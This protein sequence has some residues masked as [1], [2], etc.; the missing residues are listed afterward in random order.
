MAV[1]LTSLSVCGFNML[2]EMDYGTDIEKG[3]F[4]SERKMVKRPL[5]N[6]S[7]YPNSNCF[8]KIRALLKDIRPHFLE[9]LR[10]PDFRSCK[11]AH[12]IQERLN[13]FGLDGDPRVE[14]GLETKLLMELYKQMTAQTIAIGKNTTEN[15]PL[16][17]ESKDGPK[18]QEKPHDVTTDQPKSNNLFAKPS[19]APE[20][21][22]ADDCQVSGSYIVGGSAFGWNFI[23]FTSKDSVY[24]GVTKESF[25]AAK[26]SVSI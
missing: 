23:T 25:R 19:A 17:G 18:A 8:F 10:T 22:R 1:L 20:K 13:D 21:L 3:F 11:A 16:S 6:D 2:F 15:Q 14:V 5:H 7:P 24:Y 26:S 4:G 12:E 9:V